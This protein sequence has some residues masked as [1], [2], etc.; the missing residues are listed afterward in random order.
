M[1]KSWA[2]LRTNLP[3]A[4]DGG[5]FRYSIRAGQVGPLQPESRM[6]TN[7]RA[8]VRPL[9][10]VVLLVIAPCTAS[11]QGGQSGDGRSVRDGVYTVEQA[12]R[13]KEISDNI[14]AACHMEE[15]FTQ[16]LLQSWAGAPLSFLY[17]LLSTTMP[18]D[19]PGGLK[20]QQYADVLAYIF[21]LNGLPAGQGEL[22]PEKEELAK[23]TIER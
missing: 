18:E 4:L 13:G 5:P 9:F 20:P 10:P 15:W 6:T 16:T 14:C 21:E 2:T 23:I 22:S 19:Q 7:M 12:Q 8:E 1:R 17:E 3:G 11:A